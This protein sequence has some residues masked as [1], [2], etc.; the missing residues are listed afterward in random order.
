MNRSATSC[1]RRPHAVKVV[2]IWSDMKDPLEPPTRNLIWI[3]QPVGQ[4]IA[5]VS[6]AVGGLHGRSAR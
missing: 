4:T 1:D 2:P 3:S 5:R 6:E